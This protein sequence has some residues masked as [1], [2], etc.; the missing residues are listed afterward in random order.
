MASPVLAR[1]RMSGPGAWPGL[2][3]A[4]AAAPWPP[5][6]AGPLKGEHNLVTAAVLV[7]LEAPVPGQAEP[8]LAG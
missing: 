8:R 3:S 6:L 5:M 4:M 7:S 1:R 2:N